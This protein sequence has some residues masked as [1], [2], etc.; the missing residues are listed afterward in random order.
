MQNEKR[1]DLRKE[2]SGKEVDRKT[3]GNNE[4]IH[5]HKYSLKT[6]KYFLFWNK[7]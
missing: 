3:R 5:F 4:G 6:E 2:L 7:S 1:E